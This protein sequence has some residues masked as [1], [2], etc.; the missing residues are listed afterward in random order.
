VR[1]EPLANTPLDTQRAERVCQLQRLFAEWTAEDGRLTDEEADR[2]RT[3]LDQ[4]HGLEF[5]SPAL[6]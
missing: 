1:V 3:A 5:R 6:D 4:N 2:L